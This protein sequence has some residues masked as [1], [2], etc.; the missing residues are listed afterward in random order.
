MILFLFSFLFLFKSSFRRSVAPIALLALFLM[1]QSAHAA[2]A[3]MPWEQPLE[4]LVTSITG[5]VVR[6]VLILAIVLLGFALAFSEG[7][8]L[9]RVLG[10]VLGGAIAATAGSF[11]LEFFGLA[12][13]ATF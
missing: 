5:P 11:V 6:A 1:T 12:N 8:I 3:G 7:A 4:R 9:R 13:G 2:S 10:V